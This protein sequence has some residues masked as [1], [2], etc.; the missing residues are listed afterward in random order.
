VIPVDSLKL[1]LHHIGFVVTNI[2]ASLPG[3]LR[4]LGASSSGEIFLDPIQKVRVTFLAT[5]QGD[6]Q[7]ELIEPVTDDAPVVKFLKE[8]S[9][10]LHHLCY[11]VHD[12]EHSLKIMRSR[13]AVVAKRPKPAIAFGGRQIA[14]VLTA[15]KLLVE[16]LE[17]R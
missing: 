6:A 5:Q 17:A 1:R 2:E 11:E 3:F 12:V 10:A 15:E 4:S 16:L 9:E 8:R 14:W 7:V 13:G